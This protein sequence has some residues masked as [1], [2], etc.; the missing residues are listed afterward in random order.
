MA[1][2]AILEV[3]ILKMFDVT[4]VGFLKCK[5]MTGLG[6]MK[7][8]KFR[9]Y[10]A[11]LEDDCLKL[12]ADETQ[13]ELQHTVPIKESTEVKVDS[14]EF[15]SS[16]SNIIFVIAE[17]GHPLCFI[18]SFDAVEIENW[19]LAIIEKSR[20]P[21]GAQ[22]NF[23]LGTQ[24]DPKE[25]E[26][27]SLKT[28]FLGE[29]SK[30]GFL[31]LCNPTSVFSQWSMCY[32]TLNEYLLQFWQSNNSETTEKK[33]LGTISLAGCVRVGRILSCSNSSQHV[34]FIA[35]RKLDGTYRSYRFS[36]PN[37]LDMEAWIETLNHNIEK[38]QLKLASESISG[39]PTH[40]SLYRRPSLT[41]STGSRPPVI[42]ERDDTLASNIMRTLK[43]DTTDEESYRK[44]YLDYFC[45]P[46][47][48][49]RNFEDR[50]ATGEEE[51]IGVTVFENGRYAPFKDFNMLNLIIG[52]D[53]FKLS[54]ANGVKF[55]DR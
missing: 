5:V 37:S 35:C 49:N 44:F 46:I 23:D 7:S 19:M 2:S 47:V 27:V 25:R 42:Y 3:N 1:D 48:D 14:V 51:T 36:T 4:T 6:F 30:E 21:F 40:S 8:P 26:S 39:S 29:V 28:T 43:G 22:E 54:D 16:G 52:I 45:F 34:F 17:K 53:P 12:F 9:T 24:H 41:P 32:V 18:S 31:N 55:P 50:R 20:G 33:V 11:N 38:N 10:W 15:S 13:S